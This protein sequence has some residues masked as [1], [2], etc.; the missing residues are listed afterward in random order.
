MPELP[1]VERFRR[2]VQ[3]RCLRQR[4]RQLRVLAPDVLDTDPGTFRR[5]LQGRSFLGTARHGKYLFLALSGGGFLLM[6]FGMTGR[7]LFL[8]RPASLGP[9]VRVVFFFQDGS[10][11]CYLSQR[12]LGRLG[13]A[14]SVEAFVRAKA[15]GPD[16]LR[17]GWA[18]F[19]QIFAGLRG[20]LKPQL[21]NQH[22][23]AGLGNVYTDEV[24]FQAGLH[25]LRA[26][27][28]L[29]EQELM[30]LHG[31]MK[32][33][34]RAATRARRPPPDWLM[35]HRRPGARCPHCGEPLEVLRLGGRSTY[36]CPRMQPLG[37]PLF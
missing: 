19:R 2:Y 20:R 23:V 10:A 27:E 14:P 24:L 18:E 17:V 15:L 31:R 16:A 34:L 36:L 21:M 28:G 30:G 8:R 26:L 1:D 33:V 32:E 35:G 29:A 4:I 37:G 6:H 9:H 5:A 12:K 22:H 25:P 7:P 13:L 11:L 3:A